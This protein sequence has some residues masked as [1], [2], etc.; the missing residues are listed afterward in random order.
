M[1]LTALALTTPKKSLPAVPVNDLLVVSTS[2]LLIESI[3]LKTMLFTMLGSTESVV[4][5]VVVLASL[6]PQLD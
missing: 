3:P 4:T 1:A 6:M 2:Y 5:I